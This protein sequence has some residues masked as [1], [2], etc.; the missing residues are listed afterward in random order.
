MPNAKL[1]EYE[2]AIAAQLINPKNIETDW[3]DIAGLN[4]VIEDIKAHVILP[5]KNP[6]ILNSSELHQAPKG[7]LL[8]GPPGCGKTMIAKA[9]AKEAGAR[10]LN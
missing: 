2:F 8:H 4:G 5:L 3:S 7:V 10:Y 6:K 9:T 1:N